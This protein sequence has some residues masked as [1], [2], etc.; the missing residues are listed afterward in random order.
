MVGFVTH[1]HPT[2]KELVY[3]MGRQVEERGRNRQYLFQFLTLVGAFP[4][5]V[6][7]SSLTDLFGGSFILSSRSHGML[8]PQETL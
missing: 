8:F 6:C 2:F 5:T 4:T 1:D 3:K 7:C